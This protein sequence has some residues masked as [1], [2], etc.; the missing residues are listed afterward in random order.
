MIKPTKLTR[1]GF[2]AGMVGAAGAAVACGLVITAEEAGATPDDGETSKTTEANGGVAEGLEPLAVDQEAL[3]DSP[4]QV[5]FLVKPRHC[6]N[7]QACVRACRKHNQ[8]PEGAPGR[9]QVT[10]YREGDA[11]EI[12]VS[13]SCMHCVD[14]A[15][16]RVCPAGAIVKGAGGVVAVRADRCIGCKYCYQACPFAV[17][18]YNA[19]SMDKCDCCT[20]NGLPLGEEPYCARACKFDALSFGNVTDLLA[21]NP[22]ARLVEASTRPALV[23][24]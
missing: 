8:T 3:P 11:E 2:V 20:G 9:R 6:S 23:L 5:G 10:A 18:A 14:P 1:R 13:T 4:R 22:G 21:N 24:A 16:A 15:C 17:P 12:F 19:V 7:C